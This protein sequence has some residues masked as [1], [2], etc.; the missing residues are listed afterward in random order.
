MT[1]DSAL[2]LYHCPQT[3]SIAALWMLE[4]V[5]QPYDVC[6]VDVSA[7]ESRTAE[8]L[9]INPMGKVPALRHGA[10]IVTEVGAICLYL[11]DRFASGRLAPEIEDARR[12]EFLKWLFFTPIVDTA[13]IE[14]MSGR[15]A[16]DRTQV[17]WG[18]YDSVVRT[19]KTPLERGQ[20]LLGERF[21]AADVALG[22]NVVWGSMMK[23]LPDNEP[24]KG[25]AARA[26]ARPGCRKAFGL[27]V[28]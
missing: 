5:G 4:E 13:L 16:P 20:W 8:Y 25:Y 17:G 10:S 11:A 18:D 2:T 15:P 6:I 3:R 28:A 7:G 9:A 22:G 24:F 14:T 12:G 1:Q 21:T 26:L 23:L 19:L 27:E